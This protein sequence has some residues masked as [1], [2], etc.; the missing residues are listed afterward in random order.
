M[1]SFVISFLVLLII[2][3]QIYF[4]DSKSIKSFKKNL[5]SKKNGKKKSSKSSKAIKSISKHKIRE[6]SNHNDNTESVSEKS[7]ISDTLESLSK[8]VLSVGR[9]S[10][11]G[12][13]DL[14]S[15]KHVYLDQ[16]FGKWRLSQEVEIREGVFVSCPATIEFCE[17]NVVYSYFNDNEFTSEFIFKERNWPRACTITFQAEAF[18]GPRDE[19]PRRMLYRG[20]FKK[21]IMNPNVIFVRGSIFKLSGKLMWKSKRQVG[22]FKA[23]MRRYK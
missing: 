17:G 12:A 4:I 8:D 11:K 1:R 19:E 13:V 22:T 10:M 21:S 20:K 9:S 5:S 7:Y 2:C 3:T 18:Q 6:K 14:L 23:T 16:I 15:A